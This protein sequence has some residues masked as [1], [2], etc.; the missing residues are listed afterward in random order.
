[1]G[2]QINTL[3]LRSVG[4]AFASAGLD[5]GDFFAIWGGVEE[6]GEGG[7]GDGMNGKGMGGKVDGERQGEAW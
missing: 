4:S 6:G 5:L 2:L 1:M 7:G 3:R